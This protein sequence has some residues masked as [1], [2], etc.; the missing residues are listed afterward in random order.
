M[1]PLEPRIVT[2]TKSRARGDEAKRCRWCG[3]AIAVTGG[4]GRPREYCKRSCRQRDYEARRR[5]SELGLSER[6]LVVTRAELDQL[7]DQLYE[8]EAA[9]EDVERD[10]AEAAGEDDVRRALDWLL[11]SARPVAALRLT[12]DGRA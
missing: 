10:L 7:Y 12:G 11:E 9:I 2:V 6:E 8:L 4:P 1:V 5:S 3:R